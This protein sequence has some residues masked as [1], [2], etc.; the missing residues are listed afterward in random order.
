MAV[1]PDALVADL[2]DRPA[3][4][5][6]RWGRQVPELRALAGCPQPANHH[7]EG[8]VWRHTALALRC[9]S[10]LPAE[11][12]RWAGPQLEAAGLGRLR[13]PSRTLTQ[14]LA[15]LLHDVG[16]P[17]TIAGPDGAWTYHG[18]DR[19]GAEI[20]VA[21]VDRLGLA[22]AAARAGEAL[23]PDRLAWLI[24]E[25]LFW[26]NTDVARV[27]DRAVARRFARDD[28]WGEDLRV[29]SWCDTLGSRD[30]RGRPH[31]A[32]LVAGEVRL[33]AVR[34]RAAAQ[35]RRPGPVLDGDEV[36]ALLGLAPGPAVG[37]VL[38]WL[39]AR[40]VRDPDEARALVQQYGRDIAD[41]P[42]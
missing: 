27:T 7:S 38:G 2:R 12:R 33:A 39:A 4:V 29:L 8:D 16:K 9:L 15:V 26:L 24:R 10:D 11:V 20:A 1:D 28:G 32:L 6:E 37:R 22:A 18:H 36:M 34:A 21:V 5:L 13:L 30:P 14:A 25:H 42:A 40:R 19:R 41:H 35:Q 17:V 3:R 31:T 23:D